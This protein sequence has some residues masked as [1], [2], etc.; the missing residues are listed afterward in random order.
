MKHFKN[1][2]VNFFEIKS[3][4]LQYSKNI[5]SQCGEDGIIDHIFSI[6]PLEENAKRTFVEF[7][8]WD[9]IYMSNCAYLGMSQG[10]NGVFIEGNN[11]KF[12]ELQKNYDHINGVTL[13]NKYV[14]LEGDNIL[15]N[16]LQS[17]KI[18]YNFD[19]LSI[20]IDGTDYFVWDS[21]K[22]YSPKIVIIEF[23]PSIPNDVIFVQQK[24]SQINQGCSLL[25]LIE[26]GK[27]KGYELICATSW[28]A[29]FVKSEYYDLF[30]LKNNHITS[31][32]QPV[33]D[34]RIWHGYD[35]EVITTGMPYFLWKTIAIED[36]D[37]QVLPASLRKFGDAQ[38]R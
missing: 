23:N 13:I 6:I 35:C 24:S 9:G 2:K 1:K 22:L 14:E 30:E 7:G 27:T 19:L 20:D 10:W 25:A 31:L 26:L 3:P 5:H 15:D 32:Y 8:A 37:L 21:M 36:T 4:L 33:A 28:N 34:G 29:F 11:E 12:K 18:G 38:P 16:I 17:E